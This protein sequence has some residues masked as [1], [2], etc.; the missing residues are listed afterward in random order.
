VITADC[1]RL[2]LSNLFF[3]PEFFVHCINSQVIRDQIVR[4]T[5][6]VAQQKI[7]LERFRT[8]ALP[9]PPLEEQRR[10]L[11]RI[12]EHLSVELAA[13]K[14]IASSGLRATHLRQAVLQQAFAGALVTQS[15]SDEPASKLLERISAAPQTK[16]S[17]SQGRAKQTPAP[18]K[19]KATR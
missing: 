1:I 15:Q 2:R 8:L 17:P 10:I 12:D 11:G 14:L 16:P 4:L 9:V 18:S 7:S 13:R 6:G 19:K 5:Q 3:H